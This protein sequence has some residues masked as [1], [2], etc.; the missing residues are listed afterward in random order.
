MDSLTTR[1]RSERMGRI[2]AKD[3]KPE[4]L[5][6]R[7]VH[8]MGFRYRL[9]DARLP[10]RPDLVF[11][12]RRKA[13][14]VHGCFWH[15]HE[16]CKLARLPKS[17]LEFWVPKLQANWERDQ[18]DARELGLLGWKVLIVWECELK[19]RMALAYR[20]RE[21]LERSESHE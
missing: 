8:G 3:T 1:E 17:R 2:K 5:V 6:R 7:L 19:D 21:F 13:I 20:I 4:M 16:N 15:R 12:G 18:R 9:H 14:F 10:G 11:P